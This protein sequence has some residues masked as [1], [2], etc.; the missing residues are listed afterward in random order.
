MN[1]RLFRVTEDIPWNQGGC[2]NLAAQQART[3][4]LMLIDPDM[5]LAPD[6]LGKLLK[7]AENL[8]PGLMF[9]PALRLIGKESLDH[10]SPN[11]HLI[12][13]KDFHRLGGYDEDYAG[14][15]GYSDVQLLRVIQE[16]MV[17][18]TREDLWFQLHHGDKKFSDA[19]VKTLDRDVSHNRKLHHAKMAR[20]KKVGWASFV[21]EVSARQIRF[22]WEEVL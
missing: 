12:L 2:R 3:E 8:R 7:E 18:R 4:A 19:Q 22:P 10:T 20:M 21:K 11:V 6:M 15:K 14:H 9:R 5:T 1:A 16:A 17:S 13:R